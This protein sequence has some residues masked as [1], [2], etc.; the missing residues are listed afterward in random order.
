MDK[1]YK[2]KSLTSKQVEQELKKEIYKIK[3]I[4]TLKSTIYS[5]LIISSLAILI[6]TFI[7]SVLEIKESTMKP[8]INENEFV[9]VTKLKKVKSGDIIAFYHGNKILI[10]RVIATS[11]N[12]VNID[13]SG[14]IYINGKIINEPYIIEKSFGNFDITFPYQVPEEHYFVLSDNRTNTLDSR[15]SLIGSI[16][17]NNV[18]GKI[19]LKI[20][21]LNKFKIIK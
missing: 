13:E 9:L 14:N 17:E 8:E 5:L 11:G 21:P 10:R 7:I 20:W 2:Y 6:S 3:Y 1:D 18:I 19:V 12:W 15:N 4:K 16:S